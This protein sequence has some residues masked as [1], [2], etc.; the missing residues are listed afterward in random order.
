MQL[1][2]LCSL[3]LPSLV[4]K[5]LGML[6]P[7]LRKIYDENYS[8]KL[9][10][11]QE[12]ERRIVENA[13]QFLLCARDKLHTRGL[14]KAL[15][16]LDP[17]NP[18]LSQDSF[19]D[20]CFNFVDVDYQLDVFRFAHLSV[21]EYL[22]ARNMY[23]R[24]SN[25]ALAA[26]CCIRLLSSEEVVK[27]CKAAM[28]ENL[29]ASGNEDSPPSEL[30]DL[31]RPNPDVP[32]GARKIGNL[33]CIQFH[34]YACI[35][36]AYHLASSGDYRLVS[37]LKDLSYAFIMN[38]QQATSKAYRAWNIDAFHYYS[39]GL[40]SDDNL[41]EELGSALS[42][43][44]SPSSAD[45]VF[46]ACVWGFDDLLEIRVRAALND[47]QVIHDSGRALFIATKIGNYTAVRSVL[48]HGTPDLEWVNRWGRTALCQSVIAGS[49][50]ICQMLLDKG[51]DPGAADWEGKKALT[52]AVEN[53]DIEITRMLLRFGASTDVEDH[54]DPMNRLLGIAVKNGDVEIAQ[55][56]LEH[57]VDPDRGVF[58]SPLSNAVNGGDIAMV[59]TLLMYG[60]S[61]NSPKG[62]YKNDGPGLL[63]QAIWIGR[64]DIIRILLEHGADAN[65][66]GLLK[67]T[68]Q[69]GNKDIARLLLDNGADP[70]QKYNWYDSP[71]WHAARRGDV[72]MVKMLFE[73]RAHAP[74]QLRN[75]R[76]EKLPLSRV[77]ERF[78][79]D[80]VKLLREHGCTFEDEVEL[81]ERV[82]YSI[83]A[84]SLE[85][86][87]YGQIRHM[88]TRR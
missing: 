51:A 61:P 71:L 8:Q 13:F 33:R 27:T 44:T 30:E 62:F 16:L 10:S 41:Y 55:V 69:A 38:H 26:Q 11:Y 85:G 57:G 53:R 34:R 83:S 67:K 47:G 84:S 49:P 32:K 20:L 4:K 28:V 73:C 2:F 72:E 87:T 12:E 35:H 40:S 19:L 37:P 86:V 18:P 31:C 80:V 22:E 17:E 68:I 14:L 56:L 1:E 21:R 24:T 43:D 9:E 29:D 3:K 6:P 64:L 76:G 88:P 58:S 65:E 46:A 15:S 74:T 82:R 36:W 75:S 7:N 54:G 60:A 66:A 48:E 42:T 39:Y 52:S 50:Q 45:Y 81:E 78:K 77:Q 59:R 25:H 5:R 79:V 23:E 63:A 70:N